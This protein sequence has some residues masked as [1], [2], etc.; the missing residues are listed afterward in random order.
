MAQ[1]DYMLDNQSGVLFRQDLNNALAAL[2]SNNSGPTEP[3]NKFA[4]MYWLDTSTNPATLRLRNTENTAWINSGNLNELSRLAGVTSGIQSQINAKAAITS[5]NF[6]G[7]PTV[8]TMTEGT[9]G[10]EIANTEFVHRAI[11]AVAGVDYSDAKKT[12]KR[13]K[14]TFLNINP[15]K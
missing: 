3:P 12:I 10:V 15:F 1:H 4:G 9:F 11:E 6:K 7:V 2:A 5:P 14:A 8:P 13:A